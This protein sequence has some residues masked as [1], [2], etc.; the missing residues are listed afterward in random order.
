MNELQVMNRYL[1][2]VLEV[3]TRKHDIKGSVS[4]R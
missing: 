4:L 1:K 2:E 3:S